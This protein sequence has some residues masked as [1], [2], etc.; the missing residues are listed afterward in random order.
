[1]TESFK[2]VGKL[3]N[4]KDSVSS[5]QTQLGVEKWSQ[6][7]IL[8]EGKTYLI[9]AYLFDKDHNQILLGK[10]VEFSHFIDKKYLKL[11]ETNLIGNELIVTVDKHDHSHE[12]VHAHKSIF[13]CNLK[14]IKT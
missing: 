14:E 8:V 1:V 5:F 9:K 4:S 12:A 10:N 13:K 2:S 6:S 7:W 3:V 11:L